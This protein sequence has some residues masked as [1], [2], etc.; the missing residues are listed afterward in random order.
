MRKNPVR[1]KRILYPASLAALL[2]TF[3]Y[4]LSCSQGRSLTREET[5]VYSTDFKVENNQTL[6]LLID[7]L[8]DGAH[9]RR[10]RIIEGNFQPAMEPLKQKEAVRIQYL[11]DNDQ[12]LIEKVLDHPLI[13]YKEFS[14]ENGQLRYVR[15]DAERGSLLLRSQYSKAIKSVRI[16]YGDNNTYRKISQLALVMED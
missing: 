10:A 11:D 9:L 8:P 12:V 4:F 6:I 1:A 2:F 15:V 14:D 5:Q 7:L 16:D 13:Q 3:P